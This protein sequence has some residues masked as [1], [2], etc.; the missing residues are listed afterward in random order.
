MPGRRFSTRYWPVP[1]VIE[2]RTFSISAGLA[3]S[4]VTPGRTAIDVS[5]TTPAI[6]AWAKAIA[7]TNVRRDA[8]ENRRKDFPMGADANSGVIDGQY[9]Y[10]GSKTGLANLDPVSWTPHDRMVAG[11]R[12]HVSGDCRR[13]RAWRRRQQ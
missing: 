7:G 10:S 8:S 2:V 12:C 4:T 3:T 11:C 1:S 6:D 13:A 5:R 9:R